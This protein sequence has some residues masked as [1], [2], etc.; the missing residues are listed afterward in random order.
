MLSQSIKDWKQ[1]AKDAIDDLQALSVSQKPRRWWGLALLWPAQRAFSRLKHEE[2][3]LDFP[4][5]FHSHATFCAIIRR[6]ATS[7]GS[8]FRSSSSTNF[9][10]TS[11]I[12]AELVTLLVGMKD[13]RRADCTSSAIASSPS[14]TSAVP[15]WRR[16][17]GCVSDSASWVPT[18]ETL[19]RSYRSPPGV[20][21][22]VNRLFAQVMQP[23]SGQLPDW[24][25]RWDPETIRSKRSA[26]TKQ[27]QRPRSSCCVRQTQRR[28]NPQG[29]AVKI[30]SYRPRSQPH[31]RAN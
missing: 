1:Q 16:L 5:C 22:F 18:K 25:V 29:D 31:R 4:T 28:L 21:Q 11:P 10:D 14:M 30:P 20:L 24:F 15:T 27:W 13:I 12:Q 9:Q 8:V 7:C 17:P 3:V 19:D 6:C 23:P 26:A 2:A